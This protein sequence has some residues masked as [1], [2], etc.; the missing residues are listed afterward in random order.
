MSNP[1]VTPF[2]KHF[3]KNIMINLYNPHKQQLNSIKIF[4]LRQYFN[5]LRKVPHQK[6][7]D[8]GSFNKLK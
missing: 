8:G 2:L 7:E 3:L 4:S 5:E 1:K 6:S